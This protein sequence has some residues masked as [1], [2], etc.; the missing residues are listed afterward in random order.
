[1]I[2]EPDIVGLTG[3]QP[4][5]PG[6]PLI[7]VLKL[8]TERMYVQAGGL[9]GDAGEDGAAKAGSSKCRKSIVNMNRKALESANGKVNIRI[10][11]NYRGRG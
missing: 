10:L 6:L 1:M 4:Q 11:L 8:R 7:P 3:G 5:R 2:G 9:A